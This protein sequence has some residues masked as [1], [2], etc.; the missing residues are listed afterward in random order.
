[1]SD[2]GIEGYHGRCMVKPA[3]RE[4]I[5]RH[6]VDGARVL[7]TGTCD[8]QTARFLAEN[9]AGFVQSVDPFVAGPRI[10]GVNQCAGK[11]DMWNMNAADNAK[12]NQS[13][14][15]GVI[16]E[17]AQQYRGEL[18]DL[19]FIDGDHSYAGCMTDLLWGM[20]LMKPAGVI[21]VHDYGRID[22]RTYVP[23]PG[24]G[25]VFRAVHDFADYGPFEVAEKCDAVAVLKRR[26]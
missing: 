4:C 22:T 5:R 26:Y 21:C 17:Y 14:F 15:V 10:E 19:F 23:N 25:G 1:V 24:G 16:Q 9:G 13:L 3:E 20:L 6:M 2:Y 7:E 8:G 12:G 11:A 18:Y